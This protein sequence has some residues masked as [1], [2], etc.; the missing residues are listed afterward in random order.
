M[1]ELISAVYHVAAGQ[2][3]AE[4]IAR[5]IAVEQTVEAPDELLDARIEEEIVGSVVSV[6]ALSDGRHAVR[7]EYRAELAAG[8]LPQLLNLVY[9]NVSLFESVR[10]VE[11][12]LPAGLL[13]RFRGPNLGGQGLRALLGVYDRPLLSTA[14]KPRGRSDEELAAMAGEFALG[15]GDL[16]KDDHN[17]VDGYEAFRRRIA[18]SHEAVARAN[19]RTGRNCLYVPNLC[20]PAE[21]LP[22]FVEYVLDL[23]LRG[24]MVA[25]LILGLDTV[26]HLTSRYPVFAIAHPSFGGTFYR[27]PR[28]GI[29]PRLLL[30]TFYRLAGIDI[31]ILVSHGGRFN[32][33]PEECVG[34]ADAV[35]APLGS[36]R[37]G[38]PC[39]AGGMR[40]E[41]IPELARQYGAESLFLVGGAL[42]GH[43]TSVRASTEAFLERI[44]EQFNE[45]CVAPQTDPSGVPQGGE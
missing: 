20:A 23:G 3:D 14:L 12:D 30:G 27:D 1:G 17:L 40:F 37:P 4:R 18:L 35:R 33:P 39:P 6:E 11:L 36:L 29:A 31:S 2:A 43:T 19:E 41:R 10:L 24:I 22:R 16:V 38:L 26:R 21:Q 42:L 15:G 32:Y 8:Q 25:P 34:V 5:W 28:H 13:A 7:I 45:R 44:R 9:G